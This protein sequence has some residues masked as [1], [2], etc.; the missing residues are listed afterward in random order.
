MLK[1]GSGLFARRVCADPRRPAQTLGGSVRCTD[2]PPVRICNVYDI[3]EL[4][5]AENRAGKASD[6]P[7]HGPGTCW[8][9]A[10]GEGGAAQTRKAQSTL[11]G[12]GSMIQTLP[13]CGYAM[14]MISGNASG[15]PEHGPGTSWARGPVM[16]RA[17]GLKIAKITTVL[18]ALVSGELTKL[19]ILIHGRGFLPLLLCPEPAPDTV[20][21]NTYFICEPGVKSLKK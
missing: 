3:Y 4:A 18:G 9:R 14:Y 7:E 6:G 19:H 10:A 11:G 16:V 1:G 12:L 15:G 13:Q 2:A 8:A 20:T 5:E 21:P 17:Q